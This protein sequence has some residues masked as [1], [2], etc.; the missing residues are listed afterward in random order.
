MLFLRPDV[1][2]NIFTIFD[3]N[4]KK[5]FRHRSH[6]SFG[7]YY[8]TL[9]L[10]NKCNKCYNKIKGSY[11]IKPGQVNDLKSGNVN[12]DRGMDIG[13]IRRFFQR[14]PAQVY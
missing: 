3:E 5:L 10:R 7:E 11:K 4:N 2:N 14:E 12:H 8:K 1:K 9:Y 6:L 13:T